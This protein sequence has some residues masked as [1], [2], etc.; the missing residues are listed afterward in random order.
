MKIK[1]RFDSLAVDREF[2]RNERDSV[3]SHKIVPEPSGYAEGCE[4]CGE[5]KETWANAREN[6]FPG[7]REHFCPDTM[8]FVEEK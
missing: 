4:L 6:G 2:W 1:V 3:G 7:Y 8:V 5:P